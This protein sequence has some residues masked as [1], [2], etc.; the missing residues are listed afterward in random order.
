MAHLLK[1]E[2]SKAV[3]EKLG[4]VSN[5]FVQHRDQ[6]IAT[7]KQYRAECKKAGEGAERIQKALDS[8]QSKETVGR[9][10]SEYEAHYSFDFS[11]SLWLPQ[12]ADTPGQFYF[13]SLRSVNL[14]GIVDDGGSG[15]PS[16]VNMLY[17]QTAAGKGSSEVVSMLHRFLTR[18][19]PRQFAARRA[20]YHAD[21]CVGQ[22][23]NSTVVQFFLWCIATGISDHIELKFMLKGHTKFSPDGGFGM[24]KK[25]YRRANVYTIGQVA[26]EIK[27]STRKSERNV[28]VILEKKDFGDWKSAFQNFF[29]PMKGISGF[30]KF[31]FDKKYKIGEVHAYNYGDDKFQVH[32]LLNQD[33]N[34]DNILN[35][36]EFINLHKFL[37]QLKQP[38]MHPKKQW[39]LYE[40]VRPYVPPEYQDIVCPQPTVDKKGG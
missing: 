13:L 34:T 15:T 30:S 27:K 25:Q 16:Q 6:A 36:E 1:K 32:N 35:N 31:V 37:P 29:I 2:G 12:M 24:I 20:Y 18:L 38:T 33:F 11:Q 40:K 19:R 21:N 5:D 4:G 3:L 8:S 26:D 9:I 10:L 17:D 28:A 39:D 22:N 23:K 14:F 7:R